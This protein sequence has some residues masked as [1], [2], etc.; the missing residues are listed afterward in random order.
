[1]LGI[2]VEELSLDELF[3]CASV[4]GFEKCVDLA[5][6]SSLNSLDV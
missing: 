5:F 1:M 4:G 3:D 6:E 2:D